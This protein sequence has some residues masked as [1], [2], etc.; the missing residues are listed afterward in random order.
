[1]VD[2]VNR[3]GAVAVNRARATS[4]LLERGS[5]V[6]ARV[7]DTEEG[8]SIEVLAKVT[9]NCA[10]PWCQQLVETSRSLS[11]PLARMSKG[12]H[13]VMPRLPTEDG[14]LLLTR[15]HGGVV[16]MLPWYGRTLLG[17]TD[18]DFD[19]TPERLRVESTEAT[20]LL[21]QAN[22]VLGKTNWQ[23]SDVIS[24]FAGLRVLPVTDDGSPTTVSRELSI[25]EP[26]PHLITP[27]G[28]KYTS[29][30]AD[31]ETI[32]DL[33]VELTG[34]RHGHGVTSVRP[35]PW[36]PSGRHSR[37]VRRSLA[38]GLELGLDE[39]TIE[40]CQ[41]RY[42]NRVGRVFSFVSDRPDLAE[43][44]HPD[45]PFCL[46]EVIHAVKY[47]MARSLEDV[48]RR[49][50]PLTLLARPSQVTLLQ[51]ADLMGPFLGWSDQRKHDEVASVFR[52][53]RAQGI[54]TPT[55]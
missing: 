47:E 1:L 22:D 27:V 3:A 48:V 24:S 28:G 36:A 9:A 55:G 7:E 46:A 2:G 4:L 19:G 5:V 44:L 18:T 17:T 31:A 35:L 13:L 37:W 29:A 25:E 6:G 39:E 49:R 52:G 33:I 34:G 43:R 15:S 8:K 51:A 23:E 21:A 53:P 45:A 20:Y 32:V 42:G 54:E 11:G 41:M 40:A 26:L 30:R 12:V 50:M 38:R 16:F 10:G 14:L